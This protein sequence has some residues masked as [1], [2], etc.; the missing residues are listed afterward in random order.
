MI[1]ITGGHC[2]DILTSII[3]EVEHTFEMTRQRVEF[4]EGQRLCFRFKG[5]K[6]TFCLRR[7]EQ[8]RS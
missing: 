6:R 3:Y 8:I 1:V 2:N 5:K 4:S 7:T